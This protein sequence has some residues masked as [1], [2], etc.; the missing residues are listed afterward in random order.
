MKAP[1]RC[2]K[3][4]AS[5]NRQT[6]DSRAENGFCPANPEMLVGL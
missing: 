1:W 3:K 5:I 6:W 4:P 2:V